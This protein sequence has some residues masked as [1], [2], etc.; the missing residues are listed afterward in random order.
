LP[1]GMLL[2]GDRENRNGIALLEERGEF[3]QTHDGIFMVY[4]RGFPRNGDLSTAGYA[5]LG[6][7]SPHA[8][9]K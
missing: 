8:L 3:I 9:L 6:I 5:S 1:R 7:T 4:V 2:R